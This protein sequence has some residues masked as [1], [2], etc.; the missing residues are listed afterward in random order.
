MK[1]FLAGGSGA[2]GKRLLRTLVANGHEVGAPPTSERKLPALRE[3]GAEAV[4]LDALDRNAL[5]ATV[6]R[7]DP[8]VVIHQATALSAMGASMRN[9]AKVFARTHRLRTDG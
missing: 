6:M 2:I 8:D 4:V 5:M 1:A 7:S 9:L 3:L